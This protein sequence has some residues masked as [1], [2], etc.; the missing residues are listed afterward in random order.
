MSKYDPLGIHLGARSETRIAMTFREIEH[1][2]NFPLPPSK[3][4]RA[5]WSN[6][7]NNNVMTHQWLRAGYATEAV[8]IAAER[9]TFRRIDPAKFPARTTRAKDGP[10]PE[11]ENADAGA[12]PGRDRIFGCMSGTLTLLDGVDLTEPADAEWAGAYDEA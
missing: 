1:I 4:N 12:A 10:G 5:W 8:D 3:A 9:L 2:L 7:P 11:A 6:N